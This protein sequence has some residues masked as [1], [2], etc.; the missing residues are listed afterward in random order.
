MVACEDG[1]E[2][3]GSMGDGVQARAAGSV[4]LLCCQRGALGVY[5]GLRCFAA[6]G[7]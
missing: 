7:V 6:R 3:Q 2:A 1:R 5:L 4:A